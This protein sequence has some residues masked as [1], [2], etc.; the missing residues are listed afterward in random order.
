MNFRDLSL[1]FL[2]LKAG[3]IVTGHHDRPFPWVLG[4][5]TWVAGTVPSP[6]LPEEKPLS[7]SSLSPSLN[8]QKE[9][10]ASAGSRHTVEA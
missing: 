3:V 2:S 9:E 5:H 10:S 6:S 8:T 4:P 1:P 7:D